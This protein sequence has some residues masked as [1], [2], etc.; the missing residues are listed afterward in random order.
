ME[1][2]EDRGRSLASFY[3]LD[4]TGEGMHHSLRWH[5]E[6][7]SHRGMQEGWGRQR[8][9][10]A[11]IL[12]SCTLYRGAC[13]FSMS[14][15]M[16]EVFSHLWHNAWEKQLKGRRA[17]LGSW[18]KSVV[19]HRRGMTV[20]LMRVAAGAGGYLFTPSQT[21]KQKVDQKHSWPINL[22]AHPYIDPLLPGRPNLLKTPQS[23]KTNT[24]IWGPSVQTRT[25]RGIS[26][27]NCDQPN[28][29]QESN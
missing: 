6:R 27:L 13:S 17:C 26:H 9:Q 2:W 18:F 20:P 12:S 23:P 10:V 16:E 11:D 25:S 8:T 5:G 22:K 4:V 14:K 24:T 19:H 1:A 29:N 21:R 15:P 28:F 3:I 7:R